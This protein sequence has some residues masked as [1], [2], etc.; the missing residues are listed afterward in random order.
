MERT[1]L[2]AAD[3]KGVTLKAFL[4]G[5]LREWE[6]Q[7]IDLGSGCSDE[8]S[9]YPDLAHNLANTMRTQGECYGVLVCDTGIGMSIAANRH[10]HIRAALCLDA[11]QAQ[12]ARAHNDANTLVLAASRTQQGQACQI[13]QRFLE[14][15]FAFGRHA[16][17]V[18]KLT[19]RLQEFS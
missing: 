12:S 13:I 4:C 10:G 19:P 18:A 14:T 5:L 7:A 8:P 2:L 3:H 6:W 15:D 16:R 9:D 17:R 1:V 11:E